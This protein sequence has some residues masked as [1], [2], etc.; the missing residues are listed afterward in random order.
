MAGVKD[1]PA[2]DR[3]REKA[4]RYGIENLSDTELLAILLGQGYQGSNAIELSTTLLNKYGG[5]NHLSEVSIKELKKNKGIKDA[6]ALILATVF[7]IHYRLLSK[8]AENN[9]EIN[10]WYLIKKYHP[11]LSR[12]NQENLILV[13]LTNKHKIVFEKYLYKGAENMISIAF[14]DIKKVLLEHEAKSYYILH[15]HTHGDSTPSS[16]DIIATNSI[17]LQSKNIGIKLID[18]L[19]ISQNDYYSFSKKK[20]TAISY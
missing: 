13:L 9:N 4:N 12:C 17:I 1:L 7:E 3:P 19:I 11:I 15:N 2:L 6:K 8:A 16:Q 10:D 5:L 14:D 18:H 20:K